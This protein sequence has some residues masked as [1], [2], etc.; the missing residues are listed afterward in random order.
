MSRA[1]VFPP[2]RPA[3]LYMVRAVLSMIPGGPG[4]LNGREASAPDPFG[5][6]AAAL[7]CTVKLRKSAVQNVEPARRGVYIFA[8]CG[9]INVYARRARLHYEER[10]GAYVQHLAGRGGGAGRGHHHGRAGKAAQAGG[11][12][13]ADRAGLHV[14]HP[15][16]PQFHAGALRPGEGHSHDRSERHRGAE[17]GDRRVAPGRPAARRVHPVRLRALAIDDPRA[18]SWTMA[19][20]AKALG[21]P[22]VAGTVAVGA[23]LKLFGESADGAE[24]A[25]SQF[26]KKEYLEVNLKALAAGYDAVGA[27]YPHVPG[28]A[29]DEILITGSKAVA[30]GALAAGLT[31]YSAYP[32]SPST[33]VME[34]LAALSREAGI[35]VEQAEDEIAAIN[36]AIGASFAGA[37]AMTGTSG[38]G[39][40]LMV[41]PLG[42]TA[43][44]D[45]TVVIQNVHR[46]GP[47]T[48][49]P[50]APEAGG[51]FV[52]RLRVAGEVPAHGERADQPG[53]AFYQ[54]MR[55]FD[56]ADKSIRSRCCYS[57][58]ST[59]ATPPSRFPRPDP[60]KIAIAK[61]ASATR[62]RRSTCATATPRAASPRGCCPASRSIW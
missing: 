24:D 20:I 61:P 19:Q 18:V 38:G 9:N 44:A 14:A 26:V 17:R 7:P 57:Q 56:L 29:S 30:L 12:P 49:C 52:H 59:W 13:R 39:F 15:R 54:T 48:G 31:F 37:R 3:I 25:L 36:M 40:S 60:R 11:P 62:A 41:E 6:T 53:D 58:T 34:H 28:D 5:K 45:I 1:H 43:K 16:R 55:A 33:P 51:P 10:E 2:Y 32:M 50:P 4:R 22:K 47:V 42:L 46:P 8:N 23:V 21:N 35:V 27:R